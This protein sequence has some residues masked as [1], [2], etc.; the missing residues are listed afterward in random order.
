MS[1]E[2]KP[3]EQH[4]AAAVAE[5]EAPAAVSDAEEEEEETHVPAHDV[6]ATTVSG[7]R[8]RRSTQKFTVDEPKADDTE[9]F[10]P[11]VGKGQKIKDIA[12]VNDIVAA[13]GKKQAEILKALYLA[14]YGRRFQLKNLKVIKEHILE[15]SGIPEQDEKAREVLFA[16]LTRWKRGFVQ[17]VM[18]VLG[19]DRSKKSFDE[20]EKTF[21]KDSLVNR[22]V[23]WLYNPQEKKG[24]RKPSTPKSTAKKTKKAAEKA[25]TPAAKRKRTTK[26]PAAA[27]KKKQKTTKKGKAAV[28]AEESE[29]EE[30]DDAE[31]EG[32]EA[33]SE[34]E[35]AS[36]F[37]ESE[38]K[39]PAKKTKKAT[40]AA[41]KKSPTTKRAPRKLKLSKP[42]ESDDDD[43]SDHDNNVKDA[44]DKEDDKPETTPKPAKSAK[45][46]KDAKDV[47]SD[48][49]HKSAQSSSSALDADVKAKVKQIIEQGN[50]EELT[51]KK[52]VRQVSEELGRDLSGE[53]NA[54]KEFIKAGQ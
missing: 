28:A 2:S 52:I 51:V 29:D 31:E 12:L 32:N 42:I 47:K 44:G 39:K 18:D 23:D 3:E 11:P 14:M 15:F 30:E 54:I 4:P 10:Q 49:D 38:K 1:D 20:E 26:E 41:K 19:V 7:S 17:E 34:D 13:L 35:S 16:K 50:A 53:K 36:D 24:G 43:E 5:R 21:D 6:T 22:L 27:A 46:A 25:K 45:N 37:D 33:H 48:E 8:V 9:E 40:A